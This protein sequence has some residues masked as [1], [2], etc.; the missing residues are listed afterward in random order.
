MIRVREPFQERFIQIS[1]KLNNIEA[2]EGKCKAHR[3]DSV[4]ERT[5]RY[6]EKLK[7]TIDLHTNN[8]NTLREQIINIM[9]QIAQE[10]EIF[11]EQ[12]ELF[13]QRLE[14]YEEKIKQYLQDEIL[15]R[16]DNQQ[17][18]QQYLEENIIFIY[19]D[20]KVE[21]KARAEIIPQFSERVSKTLQKLEIR[22]NLMQSEREQSDEVLYKKAS[23][24]IYRIKNQINQVKSCSEESE[25]VLLEMLT[26]LIERTKEDLSFTRQTRIQSHDNLL[27]LIETTLDNIIKLV[28]ESIIRKIL[29]YK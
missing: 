4:L 25:K 6:E 2:K 26:S 19:S 21:S 12:D 20:L 5:Q 27:E 1:N 24:E 11:K 7:S 23:N 17:K 16:T 10:N 3:I 9:E 22:V 15:Q 29:S 14:N 8:F 18:I 13:Q 28:T